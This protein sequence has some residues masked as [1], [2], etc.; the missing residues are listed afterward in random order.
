M[1]DIMNE[2]D[3][4]RAKQLC[5]ELRDNSVAELGETYFLVEGEALVI[6]QKYFCDI[7]MDQMMRDRKVLFDLLDKMPPKP[8]NE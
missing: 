4:D 1:S 3:S 2:T 6:I 7:R 8:K 5:Q